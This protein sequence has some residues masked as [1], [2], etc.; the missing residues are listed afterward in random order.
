MCSDI[1]ANE[2]QEFSG[3]AVLNRNLWNAGD[4]LSVP[5]HSKKCLFGEQTN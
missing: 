3:A 1:Q 5:K 2:V 4:H